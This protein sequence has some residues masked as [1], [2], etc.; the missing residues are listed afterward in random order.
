VQGMIA[1]RARDFT[2][3]EREFSAARWGIAGWT[4]SVVDVARAE[5]SLGHPGDAVRTLRDAYVG[6][7]D[8]MGRYQPRSEIDY[9]MSIAFARAGVAD[10]ARTYAGYVRQAWRT[11]DPEV[12][13]KLATLMQ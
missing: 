1:M 6:P 13:R 7:L 3:A 11:A 2:T 9:W 5:L 10:S 12:R 4:V 8:A